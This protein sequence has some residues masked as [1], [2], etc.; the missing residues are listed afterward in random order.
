VAYKTKRLRECFAYAQ[1]RVGDNL[2]MSED[3]YIGH[4]FNWKGYRSMQVIGVH[5]ES[6]E[7]PITRLPRQ[8]FLWSS[9]FLQ[10]TYYFIDL[11][12]SPLR[13]IKRLFTMR[14]KTAQQT[15]G[16]GRRKIKEQYRAAWGEQ[17]TRKDGRPVGWLELFSLLEKLIYPMML[18][19]LAVFNREAFFI[20]IAVEA[21]FC[22]LLILLTAD[23][24]TR[25]KY[26][27]MIVPA[28]PVRLMGLG[29]DVVASV[30]CLADLTA[31]NRN[32]RK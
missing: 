8:L 12:L 11:P 23:R 19:Y 18:L 30:R 9:A 17:V 24:G 26:A 31:G 1:P 5:C 28:T 27:A 13:H 22:M 14:G 6:T 20:T 16:E 2:S 10:S 15:E 21:A 32:W 29:V 3:I 25:F 4:F 7:P